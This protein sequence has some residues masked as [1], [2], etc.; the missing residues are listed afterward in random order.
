MSVKILISL[1]EDL[2]LRNPQDSTLGQKII[3]HSIVLIDDLGFEAFNFKKL[4]A[5]INSTE[6]SIYRYFENKHLLLLYLVS[7]YWEW[8]SYLIKINL[9]N[10]ED[11]DKKLNIIIHA[12]VSAAIENPSV[13]YV[14]ESKLHDVVISEGMKTYYTKEVAEENSKG[15]FK[16]Y[17]ELVA[18]ISEVVLE[19]NP[20]FKYPLAFATTI[21]EMSNNHIY[22]AKHLPRLT[23]VKV[24]KNKFDEVEKMLV[25]FANRL[26]S[27]AC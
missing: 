24:E 13:D 12:L 26:L 1:N 20:N 4:A 17:K 21:F 14:N 15:F 16:N 8:V 3:Q 22:Y 19:I 25:Y 11:C 6:S 9:L 18:L 10:I 7:W 23:D 5:E 2:Y 27:P